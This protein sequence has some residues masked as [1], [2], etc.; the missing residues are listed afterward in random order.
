MNTK[1][2]AIAIALIAGT[3]VVS[4]VQA[5][6]SIKTLSTVQVRPAADQLAQQAWEQASGIPTLA[7][8]EVRPSADQLAERSGYVAAP[9]AAAMP[10]TTL[11]SVEVRPSLEQ[12]VALAAELEAQR[13]A[14][15]L[16]AAATNVANSV[17]VNLP[18]LQ[19][20]PSAADLQ[21]L[22]T[23]PPRF[24]CARN[25]CRPAQ[26][27]ARA[28]RRWSSQ[29]H[30]A[31]E[32]RAPVPRDPVPTGNPAQHGQCDPALRQHRRAAAPGR[33]TRLRTGRQA[34]QARRPG[35]PRVLAPAGSPRP[36]HRAGADRTKA[37]VRTQ[38]PGQRALRQRGL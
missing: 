26:R 20:R 13:Y 8:V 24:C 14:A 34:A 32:C 15:T 10:I 30:C 7:T 23:E 6:E 33:A 28:V 35:L 11:A 37:L 25:R 22:A 5:S 21:A 19:V 27:R 38:Y 29:V 1:T 4:S 16:A 18:A 31:D 9:V 36:G 2:I 17:I 3:A 12:R